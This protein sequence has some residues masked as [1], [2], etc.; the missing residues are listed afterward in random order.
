MP[1][2]WV[3]SQYMSYTL[4]T[5]VLLYLPTAKYKP[6]N[7]WTDMWLVSFLWYIIG[8][9][10]IQITVCDLILPVVLAELKYATIFGTLWLFSS[11]MWQY[12]AMFFKVSPNNLKALNFSLLFWNHSVC[13]KLYLK[14]D[15]IIIW[16]P[17]KIRKLVN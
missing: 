5:N 14:P 16:M 13:M 1:Q 8:G 12:R 6:A 10:S 15:I 7:K 3:I 11:S 17:K 4:N 9:P 2:K